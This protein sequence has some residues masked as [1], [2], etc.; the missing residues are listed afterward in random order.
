MRYR[1]S[2]LLCM[3]L[4]LCASALAV[5]APKMPADAAEKKDWTGLQSLIQARADPNAAQADG[6]TALHWAAYHDRPQ[7]AKALLAAGASATAANR[8]GVTALSLACQNGNVALM[9]L[10]LDAGADANTELHGGET[11]LMTAS[12]TGRTGPVARLLAKGARLE[13][14]DHKGQTALMWAA[15]EGHAQVIEQLIQSGAD[16]HVRLKSGFTP[17]LF[18]AREGHVEAVRSLLQ[19]GADPNDAITGGKGGGRGA[20]TGTS[21]L[22]FAV[23]NGHFELAMSLIK[24]GA[25]PND[26]RSGFTPLHTLTWVRKPNR[27][28]DEAGQPPPETTGSLTSLEFARQLIASGADVNAA[29]TE[30]AK[31]NIGLR[32]TGITPFFLASKTADLPLMKLLV[33]HGANPQ[34]PNSDGCTPLMAA[35]GMG[36]RAAEEEAGTEDECVDAVEYLLSIG[37]DLNTVDKKGET[38]M[39]GAA[40]KNLPKMVHLLADKGAQIAIWNQKDKQGWTPLL[41]AQGF[42]PGNFKPSAET[43]EAISQVILAEGV[44]PPPAPEPSTVVKK[45]GYKPP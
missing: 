31:G 21:A 3:G 38:A 32:M 45:K 30:T 29:L 43:V 24:A 33:Q 28:D 25:N 17:L 26:Q 41:I 5:D 20:P 39:H 1:S 10:L 19:A 42:R 14:A 40:Y 44:A 7:E 6:T 13:A 34:Q 9:G 12:R 35:A 4:C 2:A 27:G 36:T 15:A 37:A 8:Y 23:E 22:I 16:F 18:A 11:V